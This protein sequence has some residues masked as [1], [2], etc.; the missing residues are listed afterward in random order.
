LTQV[1]TNQTRVATLE[2]T[3]TVVNVYPFYNG[4]QTVLP[5]APPSWKSY[6]HTNTHTH[7]LVSGGATVTFGDLDEM[8]DHIYHHGYIGRGSQVFLIASRTVCKTIRTFR[9]A[10]GATYDFLPVTG[11]VG[12]VFYGQLVGQLPG[13]V[14]PLAGFPGHIGDYGDIHIIEE[15]LVP[16]SPNNYMV[17]W[18]SGGPQDDGNPIGLREHDNAALRG[19]KLIPQF[20][21]YPLRESFYH[22]AL[23]SGTR[24]PGKGVVMQIKASGSYEIPDLT[25]TLAAGP[26]GR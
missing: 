5:V 6:A 22:H 3:G 1:F 11:S 16:Q 26:G 19:L 10:T 18:V 13:T 2:D 21:R 24:Y 8:Y 20:E 15:D 23:G 25:A 9:V 14:N 7:Y 12:S 17:M 4:D